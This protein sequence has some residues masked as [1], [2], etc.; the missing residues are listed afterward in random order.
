MVF[1]V[2]RATFGI[3]E[4]RVDRALPLELA[5]DRLIRPSHRVDEG[6]EAAA[7]GHADHDLVG[8][9]GRRELDRLVQHRHERLEAFERE[10]LLPQERPSQVL[11]EPLGLREPV[12]EGLPLVRLERLP[13]AAGLDRLAQPDALGVIRD[14]LDLVGDRAGVDLTQERERLEQRL[15][16][17]VEAEQ[18]GGDPGLELGGQRR[19]EAGFVE[20][21]V[22]HRLG[23][24][25]VEPGRQVTVHPVGLDERHRSRDASEEGLVD[26]LGFR[27]G[28]SA[29][30]CRGGAAARQRRRGRRRPRRGSGGAGAAGGATGSATGA[31]MPLPCA[32]GPRRPASPGSEALNA[33][34]SRSNSS[35]HS[36]G[37]L[38]GASRYASSIWAT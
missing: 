9:A 16:A 25:G 22:A 7:V 6:V 12:K 2:A 19:H 35:R 31:G 28:G 30:G 38:D 21:R 24:E 27:A 33:S 17:D 13:E 11:L 36:V 18:R 20:C 29:A 8:A 10:L 3:D 14:V 5:Q 34:G 37:T 32:A 26:R 1:H 15:S 23:A 4:E